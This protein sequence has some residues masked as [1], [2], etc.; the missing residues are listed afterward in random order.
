ML[1]LWT[2]EMSGRKEAECS[3]TVTEGSMTEGCQW[4]MSMRTSSPTQLKGSQPGTGFFPW[5]SFLRN[6][7]SSKSCF[8]SPDRVKFGMNQG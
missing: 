3:D 5:F 1:T 7:D 8:L 4:T 6:S 2:G